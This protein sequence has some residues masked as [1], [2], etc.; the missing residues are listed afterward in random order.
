M[1]CPNCNTEDESMFELLERFLPG[2]PGHKHIVIKNGMIGSNLECG[3]TWKKK[4]L[5]NVCSKEFVI[6]D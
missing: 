5:C 1:K 2:I 4:Y 6:D 3:C